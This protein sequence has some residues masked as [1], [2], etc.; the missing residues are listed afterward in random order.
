MKRPRV[1]PGW[2]I[3]IASAALVALFASGGTVAVHGVG[4]LELD[5][6]L[7][8][9]FDT[10]G[11]PIVSGTDWAAF[12]DSTGAIIP[13][14]LP[15]GTIASTGVIR[16]FVP[17]ESGPDPSYHEP[18]N[19]DQQAI[20]PLEGSGVWGCVSA[21]NPTDKDDIVNAYAIA[22]QKS[23]DLYVYF[24]VERFD[25]SGTAF[26][27]VWLFQADV[28]CNL[29]TGK[30]EG[31]KST[32]DILILTDFT[33]GGAIT[34]LKAYSW[35]AGPGSA[36]PGTFTLIEDSADCD[37]TVAGDVLCGNV[38]LSNVTT[39]WPMEDKNKPG[40]PNPDPPNVLEISEFF[41][42]GINLTDAFE[43]AGLTLPDCFGSF[44]A[45]T[46]SSDVLEGATLKD[47]AL[48]D[49][50][51]CG[52]IRG[53]KYHDENADGVDNSEP[54]LS[55]WTIFIDENG[56]ETLDA[57]ETSA[58]TDANGDVLFSGLPAGSYEVC[59]KLS[60]QLGWINSDPG[61]GS[62]SVPNGT[63]LCE[64]VN[65]TPGVESYVDFGNWTPATK[66][67]MK[68]EDEDA[69]GVK[70]VG[71][72]GLENWRIYVDYNGNDAYDVGEPTDLTDASGLYEITGINPGTFDVREVTQAGWT[73]SYPNGSGTPAVSTDCEYT[74]T[75]TSGAAETDNDFGNWT[76]ASKSGYKFQDLDGDGL[77]REAGEPGLSGWTIY[78]DLNNNDTL[79]V[80][81]PT[82]V[83]D[84]NGFYEFTGLAP[85]TYTFREVTQI[86]WT[87]TFPVG[88]EY[89]ETFTSGASETGND[90]GNFLPPTEGCTPGFWQGGLGVTLWD[91]SNDSQWTF[92]GGAGTNPFTTTTLFNSFF[93]A[94]P[95]LA[96]MTML[97]IVGTGGG[98]AWP[99]K[100]ARD[101]VAAYLNASWGMNYPYIATQ[102]YGMWAAAVA[103]GTNQAFSDLHSLLAPA[104][105]LG[106]PIP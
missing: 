55:G 90:F 81:E 35:T 97:D 100:T 29:A 105:E 62:I 22:V 69:D 33:N 19:H 47:Y 27:G 85:G 36:D 43:D 56:N 26:I 64:T 41:E 52:D 78:I 42:G 82:T 49:F 94:H 77:A 54:D 11:P 80:G 25:N 79:D 17:G 5:G 39:P 7:V 9:N 87:C 8:D 4:I 95:S 103:D 1:K 70:D 45:E 3:A 71:E 61:D 68:F 34:S 46:R 48:G 93:T 67:G 44:L 66:S 73:C 92:Y 18:S 76:T 2:L 98:N 38:N 96:G 99:R 23:G 86:G 30:F 51:T 21:A 24:G 102:V 75:F 65:V 40:P 28:T 60:D 31:Q 84:A 6:N 106:C 37:T 15:T 74:E 16:D 63:T 89:T 13:A 101:V 104:N 12:Q 32:G 53:H 59:E 58:T 83:T 57:G 88:C 14:N 20:D 50:N 91:Q 10:S 72:P